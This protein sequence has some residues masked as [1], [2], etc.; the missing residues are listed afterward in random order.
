MKAALDAGL[1]IDE[2]APRLSFFFGVHNNIF[3]EVAKF[4]AAR[5]I[6]ARLMRDRFKAKKNKS[7]LLRF[8]SQTAG[9]TLTAQ[10]YENNVIRVTL[11]ALA[12]VLGGTQSLH[13]NSKDEALNL[14]SEDSVLTALRTQ[15]VIA[16]ESGVCD[17]I[18]PLGGSYFVEKL[19]DD[20]EREILQIMDRVEDMGGM[21]KAIEK[22][23]PQT[24][25]DK[26]AYLY[27]MA[28]EKND[29]VIVGLNDYKIEEE[30]TQG[31]FSVDREMEKRHVAELF[32]FKKA[33]N[34]EKVESL[35]RGITETAR[36]GG[37]LMPPIIEAV[38]SGCTV[39]EISSSLE[40]VFGKYSPSSNL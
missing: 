40:R 19:T 28:I 4:R 29:T 27:Q 8:H 2:F 6:Y 22:N 34:A 39:G 25:I 16:A 15:Q 1:D 26:S 5:R 13:T 38:K 20:L 21:I 35:L 37:N 36:G 3:E 11:Q 24:E 17:T 7:L 18:D 12:A 30:I 14:P 31:D 9:C 33:R 32:R 10:Q 23:F